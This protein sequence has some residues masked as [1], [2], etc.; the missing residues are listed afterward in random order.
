MRGCY[1]AGNTDLFTP[2]S[3]Q[4]HEKC[5]VILHYDGHCFTRYWNFSAPLYTYGITMV[6]A[7]H[8]W[9]KCHSIAPDCVIHCTFDN[10]EMSC[11]LVLSPGHF[12]CYWLED[13][14]LDVKVSG[15]WVKAK[16]ILWYILYVAIWGRKINNIC[17]FTCHLCYLWK[18]RLKYARMVFPVI[19][20]CWRF[21]F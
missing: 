3:L 21:W 12:V 19:Y 6:Y 18:F 9:P 4:T 11:D 8:H 10:S 5:I 16:M 17:L 2:G 14:N 7:V 1:T 13:F 15:D 20:N